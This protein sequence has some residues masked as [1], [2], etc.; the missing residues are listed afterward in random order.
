MCIFGYIS[1]S[2]CQ[3]PVVIKPAE[4]LG[5]IGCVVDPSMVSPSGLLGGTLRILFVLRAITFLRAVYFQLVSAPSSERGG[6]V[7]SRN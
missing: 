4:G 7:V 6:C 1:C 2:F 3:A 5:R